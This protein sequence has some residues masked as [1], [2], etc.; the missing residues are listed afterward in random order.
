MRAIMWATAQYNTVIRD[1]ERISSADCSSTS[2]GPTY[3][4]GTAAAAVGVRLGW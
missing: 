2:F 1:Y 4:S 3:R